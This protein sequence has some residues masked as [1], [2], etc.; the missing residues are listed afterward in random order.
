[1][2]T[3][4]PRSVLAF[5]RAQ[6]ARGGQQ[7]ARSMTPAERQ[8]RASKAVAAREQKRRALEHQGLASA[9]MRARKARGRRKVPTG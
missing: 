3:R 7:A 2:A 4:L 8:A 9:A 6:G 5:F 1:M